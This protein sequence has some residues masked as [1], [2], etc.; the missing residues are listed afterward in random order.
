MSESNSPARHTP[1]TAQS[2]RK[3][4]S[5]K[6]SSGNPLQYFRSIVVLGSLRSTIQ[7][8]SY[9]TQLGGWIERFDAFQ[10]Q[11]FGF[12]EGKNLHLAVGR[13]ILFVGDDVLSARSEQLALCELGKK[14]GYATSVRITVLDALANP[15][16]YGAL[17]SPESAVP[18][19][20]LDSQ[21]LAHAD[22]SD[23]VH[24]LVTQTLRAGKSLSLTGTTPYWLD[25]GVL[26]I[27][28]MNGTTFT[29]FGAPAHKVKAGMT[30]L[31]D[32]CAVRFQVFVGATGE[33]FPCHGLVGIPAGSIGHIAAPPEKIF[34]IADWS[35]LDEWARYGP[36][37]PDRSP[38][39]PINPLPSVCRN[40]REEMKIRGKKS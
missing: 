16:A 17:V 9:A 3:M 15:E 6:E 36:M 23:A 18:S 11:Q 32:P 37:S 2:D 8:A 25:T 13:T 20:M 35:Q 10:R 39:P 26:D 33:I 22:S 14:L 31:A 7:N 5:P 30:A 29:M 28:E 1:G 38:E 4:A 24:R 27:P 34:S 40:H 12:N 21:Q 19:V